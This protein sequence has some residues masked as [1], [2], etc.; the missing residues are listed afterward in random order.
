MHKNFTT[1]TTYYYD[2]HHHHHHYYNH[3]QFLFNQSTLLQVVHRYS[4]EGRIH[5]KNFPQ[6]IVL[7]HW[8]EQKLS[9]TKITKQLSA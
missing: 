4:T 6:P 3:S 1:T 5:K 2:H 9:L 7:M 8:K